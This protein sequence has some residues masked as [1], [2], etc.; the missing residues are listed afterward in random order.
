MIIDFHTHT[1]PEKIALR[2]LDHLA[3]KSQSR[4][5]SDGT[6]ESLAASMKKAGIVTAESTDITTNTVMTAT[7]I[8]K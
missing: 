6:A 7:A 4:Y 3:G 8:T 1:F 5:Y 2:T